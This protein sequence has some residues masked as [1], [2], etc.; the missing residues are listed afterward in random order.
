MCTQNNSRIAWN[1]L[2]IQSFI[3]RRFKTFLRIPINE[4]RWG[5]SSV[6]TWPM[7]K[8]KRNTNVECMITNVRPTVGCLRSN[9]LFV[10][11]SWEGRKVAIEEVKWER[12]RKSVLSIDWCVSHVLIPTYSCEAHTALTLS[13]SQTSSVKRSIVFD[14]HVASFPPS[15]LSL[16]RHS[17]NLCCASSTKH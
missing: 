9:V 13:T 15:T 17:L 4:K 2:I 11:L 12:D 10:I 7:R 8:Q 5:F 16:A 1:R 14:G 6:G 3:D